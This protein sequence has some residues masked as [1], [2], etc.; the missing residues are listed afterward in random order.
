[1]HRLTG[2]N[3]FDE[4]EPDQVTIWGAEFDQIMDAVPSLEA[5]LS[6]EERGRARRFHF[7][8]DRRKFIA[9]RGLL[10]LLLG[11]YVGT[12][13]SRIRFDYNPYGKPSL[14]GSTLEFNLSH[15]GN[16]LLCGIDTCQRVGV[17]IEK[18]RADL[19]VDS[20]AEENFAPR[21]VEVLKRYPADAVDNFFTYW[22]CKEAV[23]K[24]MGMGI[25]CGLREIDLSPMVKAPRGTFRLPLSAGPAK[26]WVVTRLNHLPGYAGAVA[27]QGGDKRLIYR[28]ITTETLNCL[29][30]KKWCQ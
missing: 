1:M 21:E 8:R 29:C 14:A 17:D 18:V 23:L 26:P 10:R 15:S 5:E 11:R 20:I 24:G 2:S 6:E 7:D 13:P 12:K 25:T 28:E 3:A 27:L 4:L 16:R 19:Q 30:Q 22:T 9:A